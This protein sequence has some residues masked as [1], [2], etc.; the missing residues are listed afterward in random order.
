MHTNEFFKLYDRICCSNKSLSSNNEILRVCSLLELDKIESVSEIIAGK[1]IIKADN[2]QQLLDLLDTALLEYRKMPENNNP[3]NPWI[4][5][6]QGAEI[7]NAK[8]QFVED[9]FTTVMLMKLLKM[10]MV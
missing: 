3:Q 4:K 6:Q 9:T 2:P 5:F 8:K 10:H 1:R 7:A